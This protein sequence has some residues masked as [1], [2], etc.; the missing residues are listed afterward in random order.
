MGAARQSPLTLVHSQYVNDVAVSIAWA[1][2]PETELVLPRAE[3]NRRAREL[4]LPGVRALSGA[5]TRSFSLA[6]NRLVIDYVDDHGRGWQLVGDPT[7]LKTNVS[8]TA[9]I[10]RVPAGE[11]ESP[12]RVKV[13]EVRAQRRAGEAGLELRHTVRRAALP[14]DRAAVRRWFAEFESC[15]ADEVSEPSVMTARRLVKGT[16]LQARAWPTHRMPVGTWFVYQDREPMVQRMLE[17]LADACPLVD[18][19]CVPVVPG[20]QVG[21]IA[22]RLDE[23]LASPARALH[24]EI[25][26]RYGAGIPEG[27]AARPGRAGGRPRLDKRGG[28]EQRLADLVDVV[29]FH[30]KRLSRVLFTTR[31]WCEEARRSLPTTSV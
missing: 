7:T 19:A 9:A 10:W 8:A 6:A 1:A 3:L 5:T 29:S 16:F 23:H 21:F 20:P 26:S 24:K 4:G 14:P 30:E 31:H 27:A 11:R 17:F 2:I 13:G 12:E 25:A 22:E 18:G 15:W 28:F